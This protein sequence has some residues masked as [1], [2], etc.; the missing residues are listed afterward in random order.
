MNEKSIRDRLVE[1]GQ[2]LLHDPKA[3]IA[4]TKEPQADA[5]LNDLDN[6]PHAFVLACIMDRQVKSERAW[7]IPYRISKKIGGFSMQK[8]S[9]LSRQDVNRLMREPEPLH[10]F[11]DTMAD[12]FYA[13]VQRI[14]ND[15][16]GDAALIWKGE[17]SSAEVVYRFLEFEGV[18][19]KI[20]NMAVNILAREFKI[21]FSDYSSID[22]SSDVHVRR[23]FSRL[24]LCDTDVTVEQVIYKAR[25]LYPEFPGIMDFPCWEIG[26]NW[27]KSR[28]PVCSGC[29]MKYLCP[30]A[31]QNEN[32]KQGAVCCT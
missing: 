3:P 7:L 26:R 9:E 10:R 28:G 19:P 22:I 18:G 24:G 12:H 5:L 4:F 15:Y 16:A 25:T 30:T 21:P 11:V 14:K 13:A 17:P 2:K 1:H 32:S 31:K 20:A 8:L 6:H 29:Y 27:C 23:V